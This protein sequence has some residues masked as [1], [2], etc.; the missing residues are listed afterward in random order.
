MEP[1]QDDR[2]DDIHTDTSDDHHRFEE[3]QIAR[4]RD[5]RRI[6]GSERDAERAAQ[7]VATLR[8]Q[9][10]V[11]AIPEDQLFVHVPTGQTFQ[12]TEAL[13]KFH[14][15]YQEGRPDPEL[16]VVVSRTT[17]ATAVDELNHILRQVKRVTLEDTEAAVAELEAV[18]ESE[19]A[20]G[21][22]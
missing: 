14:R 13:I 16:E 2:A 18:L 22:N 6:T 4:D 3:K 7:L 10:V 11:E 15:G 20:D 21:E 9:G 8:E 17:A 19:S 5:Q 1:T 12:E